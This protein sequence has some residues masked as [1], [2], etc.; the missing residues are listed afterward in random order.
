MSYFFFGT[1]LALKQMYIPVTIGL[2]NK[3]PVQVHKIDKTNKI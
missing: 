1:I 3:K 2:S